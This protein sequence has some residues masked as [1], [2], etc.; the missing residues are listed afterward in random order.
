MVVGGTSFLMWEYNGDNSSNIPIYVFVT[1]MGIQKSHQCSQRWAQW[2][3]TRRVQWPY[4][5]GYPGH[6]FPISGALSLNQ[7][8]NRIK[9]HAHDPAWRVCC[10]W[11]LQPQPPHMQRPMARKCC[12]LWV[13][14]K[15]MGPRAQ[16]SQCPQVL[17]ILLGHAWSKSSLWRPGAPMWGTPQI[18]LWWFSNPPPVSKLHSWHTCI[19]NRVQIDGWIRSYFCAHPVKQRVKDSKGSWLPWSVMNDCEG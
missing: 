4:N 1:I 12:G 19:P 10:V 5:W 17:H 16:K 15:N 13:P 6:R 8:R 7:S 18:F 14:M 3:I 11:L 9:S 2:V